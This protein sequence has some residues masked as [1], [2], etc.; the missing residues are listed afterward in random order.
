MEK[1]KIVGWTDFD[2]EYP[3]PDYTNQEL[4]ERLNLVCIEI[5]QN[6]YVFS[7]QEH[8]N[9]STG[10]PVFSDGTCFRASMRAWAS[11]MASIHSSA[12]GKR[13]SYMSFYMS[14]D[15]DS[16]LPE[17]KDIEVEPS[18]VEDTN[19]GCMTQEDSMLIRQC[20]SSNM[21]LMTYDKVLLKLTKKSD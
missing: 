1:L 5:A 18:N 19:T 7:G 12:N 16:V 17:Y 11:I 3:M 14:L 4:N 13:L 6:G 10:V 9:A 8:Q 15:E 20:L 2:S 21:P